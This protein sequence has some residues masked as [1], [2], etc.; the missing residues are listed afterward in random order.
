MAF[1]GKFYQTFKKEVSILYKLFKKTKEEET[2][3]NHESS[4][5][6]IPKPKT[7]QDNYRLMPIMNTDVSTELPANGIQQQMKR[8]LHHAWP[9][10]IHPGHAKLIQHSKTHVIDH[11]QQTTEANIWSSQ[12]NAEKAYDKTFSKAWL[13]ANILNL[14]KGVYKNTFSNHIW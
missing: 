1:I 6:L 3:L 12:L 4:I 14:I 13:E 9:G 11:H 7:S 10:R 8:R 5:A 2:L